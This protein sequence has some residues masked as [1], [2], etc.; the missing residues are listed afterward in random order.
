MEV[1]ERVFWAFGPCIDG[2]KHCMPVICIDGTHLYGKYKGTLLVATSVDASFQV[3]PI[4]FAVVEG[5]N[6]SSWS[7]FLGCI[8]DRVTQRDGLCVI[9]DRHPGIIA[10]MRTCILRILS[11]ANYAMSN[12]IFNIVL[13]FAIEAMG[14]GAHPRRKTR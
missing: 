7:W 1:F 3:F 12:V 14:L 9:S 4:A 5:E 11:Q 10:A 8:R 13:C 6:T 2:F